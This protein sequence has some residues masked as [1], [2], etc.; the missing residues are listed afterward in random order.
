MLTLQQAARPPPH[1]LLHFMVHLQVKI[2][3]TCLFFFLFK[4]NKFWVRAT[5]LFTEDCC[6][7]QCFSHIL[8]GVTQTEPGPGN[9]AVAF[10]HVD[11][12]YLAHPDTADPD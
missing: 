12:F 10:L 2:L 9:T 6:I 11:S 8:T 4:V 3:G 5:I 7:T 1:L